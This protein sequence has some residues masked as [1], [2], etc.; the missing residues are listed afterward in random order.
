MKTEFIAFVCVMA[1]SLSG[2]EKSGPS[3]SSVAPGATSPTPSISTPI[4]PDVPVYKPKAEDYIVKIVRL[5]ETGTTDAEACLK[6][7][8]NA[9]RAAVSPKTG[10]GMVTAKGGG[11]CACAKQGE[12]YSCERDVYLGALTTAGDGI[13]RN[14]DGTPM[15]GIVP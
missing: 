13:P 11:A 12:I 2:C 14:V 1:V 3:S 6:I 10:W 9:T 4:K 15:K 7:M 5:N 8:S